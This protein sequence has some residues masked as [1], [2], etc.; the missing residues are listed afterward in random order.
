MDYLASRGSVHDPVASGVHGFDH[1][2][3]LFTKYH[4][5]NMTLENNSQSNTEGISEETLIDQLAEIVE[6]PMREVDI[7][8]AIQYYGI[9]ELLDVI[10]IERIESYLADLQLSKVR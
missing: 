10:G 4:N 7:L 8:I 9:V 1:T 2:D 6:R 5:M 3:F